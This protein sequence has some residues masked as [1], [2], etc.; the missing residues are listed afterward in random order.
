MNIM[1][2]YHT[3]V[4]E[5]SPFSKVGIT[6]GY[7][8]LDA[9]QLMVTKKISQIDLNNYSGSPGKMAGKFTSIGEE[10]LRIGSHKAKHISKLDL[11][12]IEDNMEKVRLPPGSSFFK[13]LKP[14][15]EYDNILMINKQLNSSAS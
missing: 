12:T 10:I 3:N 4:K 8:H 14:Q 15:R 5:S 1:R 13:S 6:K 7:Y 11:S 9:D 2:E